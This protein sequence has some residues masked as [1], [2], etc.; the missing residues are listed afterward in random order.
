MEFGHFYKHFV[1]STPLKR[2]RREKFGSFFLLD[3][4]K[5]TF[6]N[7]NLTQKWT[8]FQV[9]AFFT[10]S[11]DFLFDFQNKA[12]ETTPPPFHPL[13]ARLFL[14]HILYMIF[15]D[16][17][18]SSYIL[19]VY[20]ISLPDCLFFLRYWLIC[21]FQ[22]FF[23]QLVSSQLLKLTLAVFRLTLAGNQAV[24]RYDQKV[25]TKI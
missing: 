5:T 6:W 12:G 18:F 9:R 24:F 19:S 1:K 7:E 22:L 2:L 21:V 20:Q 17:C 16:K 8:F 13:V 3:T 11:G 10:K 4:L 25:K 14:H 15:Q 23:N